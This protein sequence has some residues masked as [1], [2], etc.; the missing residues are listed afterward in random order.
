MIDFNNQYIYF[1]IF[2]ID[3]Y[4]FK[5]WIVN[6]F[7]PKYKWNMYAYLFWDKKKVYN[8]ETDCKGFSQSYYDFSHI[9]RYNN[10]FYFTKPN[11]FRR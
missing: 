10:I 11:G 4:P 3:T 8:D 2:R 5:N 7:K 1:G 6:T 9:G